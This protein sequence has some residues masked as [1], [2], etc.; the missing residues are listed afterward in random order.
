M[1]LEK[2]VKRLKRER[3]FDLLKIETALED[4]DEEMQVHG[5]QRSLSKYKFRTKAICLDGQS[6][7]RD[8]AL[9]DEKCQKKCNEE[10]KRGLDMVKVKI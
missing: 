1:N 8:D 10:L 5:N 4:Y 3:A 6:L 2:L 9:N 7:R